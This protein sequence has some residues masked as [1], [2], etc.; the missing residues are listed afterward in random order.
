MAKVN[1][2]GKNKEALT[3]AMYGLLEA[4]FPEFEDQ[5]AF[6]AD[7][8]IELRPRGEKAAY[9]YAAMQ[10]LVV[11]I[12]EDH[13]G[14][15]EGTVSDEPAVPK[16]P[17][18]EAP[19]PADARPAENVK[20]VY[21]RGVVRKLGIRPTIQGAVTQGDGTVKMQSV[22]GPI[23]LVFGNS[24]QGV[25][26]VDEAFAR[27]HRGP[28]GQQMTLGQMI[29]L[30]ESH[31]EFQAGAIYRIREDEVHRLPSGGDQKMPL[32]RGVVTT[33]TVRKV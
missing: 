10:K 9:D 30:I 32:A 33:R 24:P 4:A 22:C 6:A 3:D 12:Q 5:V 14:V 20:V 21:Y 16:G 19:P 8:G 27:S 18:P 1:P 25:C 23:H 7:F 17:G 31:S 29:E 26:K 2:V 11:E 15:P 28:N 13:T